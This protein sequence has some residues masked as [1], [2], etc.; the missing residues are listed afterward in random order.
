MI[1]ASPPVKNDEQYP[2]LKVDGGGDGRPPLPNTNGW[3]VAVPTP[4]KKSCLNRLPELL[5]AYWM[6]G[7]L[8]C[9][10]L[11]ILFGLGLGALR[12]RPLIL[13]P[14]NDSL[15]AKEVHYHQIIPSSSAVPLSLYSE[16]LSY[17]ASVYSSLRFNVNFLVD[18]TLQN[19]IHKN[20][21]HRN[22]GKLFSF[23]TNKQE[24]LDE[25]IQNKLESFRLKYENINITVIQLSKFMAQT[26]L[27][28]KW[29][30][31]PKPYL[32][33]YARVFT[34]WQRGG[35]GMDLHIFNKQFRYRQ[36]PNRRIEAILKQHNKGIT[37]DEYETALKKIDKDEQADIFEL[38]H[39]IIYF[40]FTLNLFENSIISNNPQV[41]SKQQRNTRNAVING[42]PKTGSNQDN[43]IESTLFDNNIDNTTN[44]TKINI[45]LPNNQN[46]NIQN[47]SSIN[48][49]ETNNNKNNTFN[50]STPQKNV[51]E[52]PQI[53]LFDFYSLFYDNIG[54]SYMLQGPS[55]YDTWTTLQNKDNV[56]TVFNETK[57]LPYYLS[58]NLDGSFI[59]TSL[60]HHPL[61]TYI[62][63]SGCQRISPTIAIQDAII[64]QCSTYYKDDVYCSN[65]YII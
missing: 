54:P 59:A 22:V 44:L 6:T 26:P 65:I 19:S 35:I 62:I 5:S 12:R 20:E 17:V 49:N 25:N 34:V 1:D 61:L 13:L 56:K 37:N 43:K 48:K 10:F 28:Y 53:L 3:N 60:K 63:S 64:A 2:L 58:L 30:T 55:L 47:I 40:P 27:R 23:W 41:S 15:S 42:N 7:I 24:Q 29:K 4:A 31:I 51:S 57:K 32:S 18:D 50:M 11:L 33:F 38:I 36:L 9:I 16:Y 45:I 8:L 52:T 14:C 39:Q 46:I 21:K